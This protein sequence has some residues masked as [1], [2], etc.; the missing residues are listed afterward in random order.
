M[1][2]ARFHIDKSFQ[3]IGDLGRGN[4]AADKNEPLQVTKRHRKDTDHSS[5]TR[6]SGQVVPPKIA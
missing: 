4:I 6:K 2:W 5:N 3:F 1:A